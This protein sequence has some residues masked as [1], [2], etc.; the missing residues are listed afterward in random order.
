MEDN[1]SLDRR[2]VFVGHLSYKTNE[3][4]LHRFFSDCGEINRIDLARDQEGHSRGWAYITFMEPDG[5]E[6]AKT[7]SESK[8]DNRF[9]VVE[10][11]RPRG[12]LQHNFFNLYR[13]EESNKISTNIL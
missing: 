11:V 3:E 8:I 6:K 13:N 12:S 4:S 10:D 5:A 9:I 1:L 7:K 2:K